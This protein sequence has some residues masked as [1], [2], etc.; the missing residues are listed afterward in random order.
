VTE[1]APEPDPYMVRGAERVPEPDPYMVRDSHW[2]YDRA[3]R[4]VGGSANL[5][6]SSFLS[7]PMAPTPAVPVRV[8]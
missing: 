2:H 7:R 3:R 5:T 4:R 8:V 6:A 1:R